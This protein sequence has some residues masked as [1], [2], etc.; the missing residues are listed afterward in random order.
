[1]WYFLI[2]YISDA[3]RGS[4]DWWRRQDRFAIIAII[5]WFAFVILGFVL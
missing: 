4:K 3:Y 5:I 1:M 2:E